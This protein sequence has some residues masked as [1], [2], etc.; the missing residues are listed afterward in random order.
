M[1]EVYD[2]GGKRTE[3]D[4]ALQATAG[5]SGSKSWIW[6]SGSQREWAG[7]LVALRA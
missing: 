1:T 5:S 2:L 6:S 3:L 7:W 4:D